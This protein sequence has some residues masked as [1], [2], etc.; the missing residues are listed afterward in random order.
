MHVYQETH[1]ETFVHTLKELIDAQIKLKEA[2]RLKL[3]DVWESAVK[4]K[5]R[6][7]GLLQIDDVVDFYVSMLIQGRLYYGMACI[8]YKWATSNFQDH[9][10]CGGVS[11]VN[12]HMDGL[13]Y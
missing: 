1:E 11:V 3:H 6:W 8:K 13:W 2:Y 4:Q 12:S 10:S 5:S 7:S 9:S